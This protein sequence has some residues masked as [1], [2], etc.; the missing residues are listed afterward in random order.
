MKHI[1]IAVLAVSLPG[2]ASSTGADELALKYIRDADRAKSL[3]ERGAA[4]LTAFNRGVDGFLIHQI[5]TNGIL[6]E[7][8]RRMSEGQELWKVNPSL[9]SCCDT[10]GSA[11][12]PGSA[13]SLLTPFLGVSL[14]V[15]NGNKMYNLK[16]DAAN[17]VAGQVLNY[18]IEKIGELVEAA[19]NESVKQTLAICQSALDFES[20]THLR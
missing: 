1:L 5:C 17:Y 16:V 2:P 20:R 4:V 9:K 8:D 6:A 14:P 18:P 3:H 10:F 19:S 12:T 7:S 15:T 11:Y 13:A